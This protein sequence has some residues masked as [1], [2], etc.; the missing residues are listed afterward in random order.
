MHASTRTFAIARVKLMH[1]GALAFLTARPVLGRARYCQQR[2][3]NYSPSTSA[4]PLFAVD[5]P[6]KSRPQEL[7]A[8]VS[9][10]E[11]VGTVWAQA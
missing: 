5:E 10:K 9:K 6:P 2:L 1:P 11:R 4:P 3:G 7:R 8:S